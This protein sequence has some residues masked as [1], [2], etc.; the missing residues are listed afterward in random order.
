[1][2]CLT[3][4]VI[5]DFVMFDMDE[6]VQRGREWKINYAPGNPFPHIVLED[7][8]PLNMLRRVI[9]EF[10]SRQESEIHDAHSILKMGYTLE[11]I[12]SHYITNLLSSLTSAQF[13][14]FL[15][16]LTSIASVDI[17]RAVLL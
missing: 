8:L 1:M 5:D 14:R 15:E 9:D 4:L 11:K 10:P 12:K 3:P 13:L 7:F 6:C 2:S 16:E 17:S